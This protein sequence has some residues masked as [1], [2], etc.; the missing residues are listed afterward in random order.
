MFSVSYQSYEMGWISHQ[1]RVGRVD[2]L[3]LS[4]FGR[5]FEM[6]WLSPLE[7]LGHVVREK[8][9]FKINCNFVILKPN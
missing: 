4:P 7:Q 9:F 1:F 5:V 8:K 3:H 6:R 2:F